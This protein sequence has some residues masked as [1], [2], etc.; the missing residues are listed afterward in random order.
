MMDKKSSG[1]YFTPRN[2][3]DFMISLIE[4]RSNPSVLEP[5]AG[6]GIF[7]SALNDSGIFKRIKAYEIDNTLQN[8]SCIKIDY[9]DTLL[10]RPK[11]KFDVIIGN[12]PY[13]RWKNIE[14][15]SRE[16]LK[17]DSYWKSKIN[18][19]NDLLYPFI[20]FIY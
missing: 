6:E 14:Q 18:G 15:M 12:P 20:I 10:D 5:C 19:L 4:N 13:V 3:A 7:L 11:E 1:Q 17:N 9:R 2:I 16:A 8:K